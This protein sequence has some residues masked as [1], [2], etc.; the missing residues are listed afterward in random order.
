MNE[1]P[2][3]EAKGRGKFPVTLIMLFLVLLF[4]GTVAAGPP[5]KID[6]DPKRL[7]LK[8]PPGGVT[9][10]QASFVSDRDIGPLRLE[11]V[12]A[13]S[14]YL[15]II[16]EEIESV[17]AGETVQI[18]IT[19]AFD[20]NHRGSMRAGTIHALDG[21]RSLAGTLKV[22]LVPAEKGCGITGTVLQGGVSI[23]GVVMSI[24]GPAQA[25][26][27]TDQNGKFLF[28]GLAEGQYTVSPQKTG[29]SFEP[30]KRIVEIIECPETETINFTAGLTTV[31]I[32]ADPQTVE[33]TESSTLAWTSSNADACSI[34]PDIGAVETSG[35]IEVSPLESTTYAITATGPGDTAADE[36]T[37][38]VIPEDTEPLAVSII[39]PVDGGDS[40][41]SEVM[42]RGTVEGLSGMDAGVS[43]NCS[44]INEA[45]FDGRIPASASGDKFAANNIPLLPGDNTI[46]VIVTDSESNRI[47]EASIDVYHDPGDH[48]LQVTSNRESGISP[49]EATLELGGSFNINDSQIAWS[50]P[51]IAEIAGHAPDEYEIRMT[52]T[53]VYHFTVEVEDPAGSI[54]TDDYAFV[55]MDAEDLD[56]SLRAKWD[57]MKAALADQDIQGALNYF[58]DG[59]KYLYSDIYTELHDELPQITNTM[60]EIEMI[61]MQDNS[62]KYRILKDEN[63]GGEDITV[64]YYVYFVKSPEG[65]WKIYRY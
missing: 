1:N 36:V 41:R 10:Q 64:S 7:E 11:A 39:V 27:E 13:I 29:Y 63:Y 37:V 50:G 26:A 45:M 22:R 53:G 18:V 60:K 40:T 5:P 12:P 28:S 61:S 14:D 59:Q 57:S 16:P 35:S 20:N 47:G 31:R 58:A 9:R 24:A 62:A 65:L 30:Q 15:D 32:S 25:T 34:E 54:L 33:E 8:V 52:E 55:V 38:E 56:E 42:V 3:C 23:E 17:R 4:A 48:T 49:L 46:T 43:V 2:F 6:W 51:G 19:A 44:A 21:Q